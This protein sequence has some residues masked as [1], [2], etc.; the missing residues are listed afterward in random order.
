MNGRVSGFPDFL[1]AGRGAGET[2][3]HGAVG[4]L[5]MAIAGFLE[6]ARAAATRTFIPAADASVFGQ[7]DVGAPAFLAWP[8]CMAA[9]QSLDSA[10][11]VLA[12]AASQ[13]LHVQSRERVPNRLADLL[14]LVHNR[15]PPVEGDRVL[16][17]E[18]QRLA[19]DLTA[20]TFA[21]DRVGQGVRA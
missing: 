2:D 16:G 13:A 21:D 11:A 17:P 7:D 18:M 12:V 10:L 3:G 8:K 14:A 5:P 20:R 6:E 19:G 15:V 1:L 9:G 4:Y